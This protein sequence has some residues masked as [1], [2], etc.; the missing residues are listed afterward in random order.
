MTRFRKPAVT[1]VAVIVALSFVLPFY[2][3]AA[4]VG[5]VEISSKGA[6]VI[7]FETGLLIYGY[8]EAVQRVPASMLKM[9]A[10]H[11]VYDAIKDGKVTFDSRIKISPSTSAFSRNKTYSNVVLVEGA[12]YSVREL[13]E[14]VIVRS[15]CAATVALGE[16]IF[17][18]ERA[19]VNKMNEKARSLNIRASFVDCWGGSPDNRV[20]PLAFAWLMRALLMDHP[21]V[22]E[23][24]SKKSVTFGG[25]TLANSNLRL[26]V[27]PGMDGLK[28]GFT[29]PAGYCFTGTAERN[30][31]RMIAVTMGSTLESRYPDADALLDYG[32]A[33]VDRIV[34][35]QDPGKDDGKDDGQDTGK[36]DG[37]DPGKD[38]GQDT[39][40]D[41]V[42][43]GGQNTGPGLAVP[44]NAQ[45]ILNGDGS[46]L[47]AYMI[48]DLH[49]FKLRDI[50][51]LLRETGRQFQVSWNA[52]DNAIYLTSAIAYSPQGGE[53]SL[54]VEGERPYKPT[55]SKV[56]LDGVSHSFES[57]FIDGFNYFKLR[58]LAELIGFD[59][60]W[61]GETRT[62]IIDTDA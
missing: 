48:N 47:S 26:G 61:I 10:I 14:V 43:S 15:A 40:K 50:A 52:G 23:I 29:D 45:L 31:R 36:D 51:F 57:Y 3:G 35:G 59:V 1:I 19:I 9:V 54:A 12:T 37:K 22:L 30:G 49:Y 18:S 21:G 42:Q 27:Y 25:E 16:G 60:E 58:D 5:G 7:D 6:A 24:S 38:V 62:V 44:S 56:F 41:P 39:G 13:V 17:G 34:A 53:L 33:N 11:V 2:A 46:P 32:F 55:P 28:T 4:Y 8:N 20:S